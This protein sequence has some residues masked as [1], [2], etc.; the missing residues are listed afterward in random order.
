LWKLSV[1]PQPAIFPA[2]IASIFSYRRGA[3][4]GPARRTGAAL[5]QVHLGVKLSFAYG[6]NE[7]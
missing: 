7:L 1:V 3:D 4:D 5:L 2:S 6:T